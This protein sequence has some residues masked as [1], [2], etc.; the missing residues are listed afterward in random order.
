MGLR[1]IGGG[2]FG[3]YGGD[4]GNVGVRGVGVRVGY[5][6]YASVGHVGKREMCSD[7]LRQGALAG[8]AR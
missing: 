7:C 1:G 3:W 6:F 8:L 2:G 5:F 4:L